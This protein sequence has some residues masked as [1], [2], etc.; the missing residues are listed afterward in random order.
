[1][2]PLPNFNEI[3]ARVYLDPIF[4]EEAERIAHNATCAIRG[5]R[6]GDSLFQELFEVLKC[7]PAADWLGSEVGSTLRECALEILDEIEAMTFE[8]NKKPKANNDNWSMVARN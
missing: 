4:R 6:R 2:A 7:M 5:C 3:K 1:M 8:R